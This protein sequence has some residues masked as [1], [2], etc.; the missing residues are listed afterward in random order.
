[1]SAAHQQG[2]NNVQAPTRSY[3]S[4]MLPSHTKLKM[5][6]AGQGGISDERPTVEEFKTQLLEAEARAVGSTSAIEAP[7]RE[8]R[9]ETIMQA[10]HESDADDSDAAADSDS[11]AS[12]DDDDELMLE[13][14]KI[15]RER[16]EEKE[17]QAR[18]AEAMREEEVAFGNPLLNKN[19]F[20]VKRRWD[21]DVVFKN[22]ARKLDNGKKSEFV[23][24]MIRSDF[25][26]KFIAR[27]IR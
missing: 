5:R 11:L 18:E 22:Q 4:R 10:A 9:R 14:E 13:L 19:E 1:M 20:V 16:A 12:S 6:E 21:D 3:S 2:R 27:Y 17:R 24:D 15:R 7:Y 26:R 8:T 25:H 23:N